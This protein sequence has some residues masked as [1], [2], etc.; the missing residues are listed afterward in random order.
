MKG[1]GSLVAVL[2]VVALIVGLLMYSGILPWGKNVGSDGKTVAQRVEETVKQL[3]NK[4]SDAMD[5]VNSL[6][7]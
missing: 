5:Q 2:L 1:I 7:P 6:A 4:Q 3:T